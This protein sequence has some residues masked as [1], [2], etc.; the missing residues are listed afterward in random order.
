PAGTAPELLADA[1]RARTLPRGPGYVWGGAEHTAIAAVRR[2]VGAEL[3][4]PR[5][6]R[7]LVAY[8]HADR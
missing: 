7:S 5:E 2:F 4:L 8:W 6:R 1:V 3:G